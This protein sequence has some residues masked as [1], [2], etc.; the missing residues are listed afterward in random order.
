[1]LRLSLMDYYASVSYNNSCC[2][3]AVSD[4]EVLHRE[5]WK[6][7]EEI[8]PLVGN[9]GMGSASSESMV[10]MVTP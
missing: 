6:P 5:P 3:A 2:T 4:K 1:M 10:P 9:S 7:V 8:L